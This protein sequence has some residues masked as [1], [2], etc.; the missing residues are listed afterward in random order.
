MIPSKEIN[1]MEKQAKE[2]ESFKG[3]FSMR[4]LAP[5]FDKQLLGKEVINGQEA[6]VVGFRPR[7]GQPYQEKVEK[8]L[9]N[10]QGKIWISTADYSILKT[11]A[12]LAHDVD[13]AWFFATMHKLDFYYESQP[14]QEGRG[15]AKFNLSY[16]VTALFKEIRQ[17]QFIT[18]R[19]F[20]K[21]PD[22]SAPPANPNNPTSP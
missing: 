1:T 8:I 10:L 5:R 21:I 15:P 17:K 7:D 19:D 18:M 4:K 11:D 20:T 12:T 13:L 22:A 6:Y 9:N 3:N 14:I 16:R 2:S